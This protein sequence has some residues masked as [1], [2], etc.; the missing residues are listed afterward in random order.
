MYH[1]VFCC[2]ENEFY[3]CFSVQFMF[4]LYVSL[5]VV[6][7]NNNRRLLLSRAVGAVTQTEYGPHSQ[8]VRS[9]EVP[10]PC[11]ETSRTSSV[12][13]IHS[14]V[15][16]STELS[17]AAFSKIIS[18]CVL[19]R[20]VALRLLQPQIV[21]SSPL[22]EGGKPL[23]TSRRQILIAAEQLAERSAAQRLCFADC[24]NWI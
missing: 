20:S 12:V 19:P 9:G 17:Q 13:A 15:T 11:R 24:R 23:H 4:V 18:P 1:A 16:T 2:V 14:L 3:S 5:C 8:F 6:P 7:C 21:R 22:C 10:G